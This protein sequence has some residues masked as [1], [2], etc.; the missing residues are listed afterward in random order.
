[1][2]LARPKIT[3]AAAVV[4]LLSARRSVGC[5]VARVAIAH[6]AVTAF[7][8]KITADLAASD[9]ADDAATDDAERTCD[10]GPSD[11]PYRRVRHPIVRARSRGHEYDRDGREGESTKLSHVFPLQVCPT[12]K[13]HQETSPY[14]G[15]QHSS[16]VE[17]TVA[18]AI[19]TNPPRPEH[20]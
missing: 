19:P 13:A 7:N 6:M 9:I 2:I 5:A 11:G 12:R 3:G 17:L 14:L 1:V 8:S 18:P 20:G 15:R 4:T 10:D 16:R